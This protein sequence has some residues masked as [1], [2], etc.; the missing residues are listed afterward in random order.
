VSVRCYGD[1]P[2]RQWRGGTARP[3]LCDMNEEGVECGVVIPGEYTDISL[4]NGTAGEPHNN[5]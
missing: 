1:P 3:P 4:A 2:L 5:A